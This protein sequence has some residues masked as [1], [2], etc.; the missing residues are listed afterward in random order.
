VDN[1]EELVQVATSILVDSGYE[2]R[3]TLDSHK[4]LAIAKKFKPH[5]A[6]VGLIMHGTDGVKLGTEIM[7]LLNHTKVVL[8]SE[9]ERHDAV[10]QDAL[11][12]LSRQGYWFG[13]LTCPFEKEDF[14][15]KMRGWMYESGVGRR[16][17][18]GEVAYWVKE[19]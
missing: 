13:A 14:L 4:A 17:V 1:Q 18:T 9:D 3:S 8:L 10:T 12:E 6:L 15:E 5:I 7:K 16:L 19:E 2:V 11:S